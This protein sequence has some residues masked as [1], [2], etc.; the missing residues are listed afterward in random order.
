[1]SGKKKPIYLDYNATTPL[2]PR[3]LEAMVPYLTER[4]GNAS[5]YHQLG[6]E[7][8]TAVEE[9][10]HRVAG[11]LGARD[12][13]IVFTGGG[14]EADNLALRGVARAR[15]AAGRHIVTSRIEHNAV[16]RTC[17]DLEGD[18]FEVTLV[19]VDALGV[20]DPAQVRRALRPG[21]PARYRLPHRCGADRRQG[22]HR[23][24]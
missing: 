9:A 21:P 15:R 16:L 6:R 8:R 17:R 12:E 14:T 20:V 18:G 10:R 13:E 2:D 19:P 22:A 11:C 5:S 23:R 24:R 3:V 7:A 4:F 1:M